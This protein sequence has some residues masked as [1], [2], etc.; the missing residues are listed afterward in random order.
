LN[1]KIQLTWEE[2]KVGGFKR[3]PFRNIGGMI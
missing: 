3:T 1:S 2:S